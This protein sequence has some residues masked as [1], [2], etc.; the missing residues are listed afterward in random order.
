MQNHTY[1]GQADGIIRK[2]LLKC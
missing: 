1:V 2:N